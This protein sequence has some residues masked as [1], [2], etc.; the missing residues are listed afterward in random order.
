M[1]NEVKVEF[2]NECTVTITLNSSVLFDLMK[3]TALG[4]S[5]T[6]A[7]VFGAMLYDFVNQTSSEFVANPNDQRFRGQT[8][9]EADEDLRNSARSPDDFEKV[10]EHKL[11]EHAADIDPAARESVITSMRE[12]NQIALKRKAEFEEMVKRLEKLDLPLQ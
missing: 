8:L 10:I 2:L 6:H 1:E 3:D 12:I 9:D 7:R 11:L 5:V 4:A